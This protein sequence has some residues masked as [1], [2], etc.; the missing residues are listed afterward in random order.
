MYIKFVQ[1][2][3]HRIQSLEIYGV[4]LPVVIVTLPGSVH[5]DR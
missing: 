3:E 1:L 2:H 5:K 4:R